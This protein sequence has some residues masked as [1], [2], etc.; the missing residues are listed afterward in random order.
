MIEP[1]NRIFLDMDGVLNVGAPWFLRA[2]GVSIEPDDIDRYPP[3]CGPEIVDAAN[4]LLIAEGKPP[5][6]RTQFWK[7]TESVEFWRNFPVSNECRDIVDRSVRM[8][9]DDEVYLLT[10][11]TRSPECLAGKLTWI[12]NNLPTFLH[13]QYLI[14]PPKHLCARPDALL[15]DDFDKNVNAFRKAGGQALLVPR[16]W[17]SNYSW[18]TRGYINDDFRALEAR[19]RSRPAAGTGGYSPR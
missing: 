4:R 9:G 8:V 12:Q 13:R 15:I 14:G 3:D 11:T 17:N 7:C 2:A 1:I 16:P 10:S 5:L 6:T 19:Q 18:E